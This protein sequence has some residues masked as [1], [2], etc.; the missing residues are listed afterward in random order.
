MTPPAAPVAPTPAPAAP[1]A[2]E[3]R[4]PSATTPIQDLVP[5]SQ[6]TDE[7]SIHFEKMNQ[8]R[9]SFAKSVNLLEKSGKNMIYTHQ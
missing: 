8:L 1:V 3:V 4:Q 2:Q 7:G 6:E 9:A 5:S